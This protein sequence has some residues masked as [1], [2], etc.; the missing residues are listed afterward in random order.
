MQIIIT[1]WQR[2]LSLIQMVVWSQGAQIN[3]VPCINKAPGTISVLRLF[4]SRLSALACFLLDVWHSVLV[5][6]KHSTVVSRYSYAELQREKHV[7][8]QQNTLYC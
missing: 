4:A 2:E 1:H 7:D 5:S 3:E 8:K 6:K